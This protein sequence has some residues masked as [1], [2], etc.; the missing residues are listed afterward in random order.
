M[1]KNE[2]IIC[3]S[4]IDWDFIWQGHQE[5]MANFARN[6]NKVLYIENTGIRSPRFED[7]PRLL[8]R[9]RNWSKSVKGFREERKNLYVFSPLFFPFPYS[10][11]AQFFNNI[12]FVRILK[13]WLKINRFFDPILWTFLPTRTALNLTEKIFNKLIVYYCIADFNELVKN[14]RAFQSVEKSLLKR[15][16]VVFAQGE[17]I[18]KR[19]SQY[20]NNVSIFPF[21]VNIENFDNLE[22]P[23]EMFSIPKPIIGY[24]GGIHRHIDLKLLKNLIKRNKK[25]S[26][27]FVGPVQIDIDDIKIQKNAY[28]LGQKEFSELPRYI[29]YFDVCLIPYDVSKYTATVYP[30]KLNEYFA[31]GKPVVSTPLPEVIDFNR[32]NNNSVFLASTIEEHERE[33]NKALKEEKE[34]KKKERIEIAKNHSWSKTIENMSQTIEKALDEKE[35]KTI[36]WQ[37]QLKMLYAKTRRKA[38]GLT[39]S[40]VLIW[41]LIFHTPLIWWLAK[42]LLVSDTPKKADAIVVLAGGVGESGNAGQGYEERVQYS[43]ELYKKDFAHHL[44]FS[45][46]YVYRFKEPQVM[47]ALAISLGVKEENIILEEKANSTYK[48]VKNVKEILDRKGW[49]KILL[50]SSPF[51]MR[52]VSLV[53]NRIAKDKNILYTPIPYSL[54]YKWPRDFS[55]ISLY[56][57]ITI[58]QIR[59]LLHEYLGIVY[60]WWKG[61]I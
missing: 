1:I 47:K 56:K 24:I 21:G 12:L 38:L 61:W 51:H 20:N 49:N 30:T 17:E 57:Q 13:R 25:W 14:K 60:Y 40:F 36:N 41:I 32:K 18:K 10:R 15:C 42:P 11:V 2:N 9:V 50:V 59:G 5:I 33:I 45:S 27:V 37:E 58:K 43:V 3:I 29:S 8:K 19:C 48:N 44:M 6:G 16:D 35:S 46:G 34:E 4:S 22:I 23:P 53:S 52:R 54:Y 7:V 39:F 31:M 55:L 28:F 26:F